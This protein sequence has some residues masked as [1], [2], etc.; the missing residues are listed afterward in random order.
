MNDVKSIGL[1]TIGDLSL[2]FIALLAFG[3]FGMFVKGD[4]NLVWL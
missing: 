3:I 2:Y 1:K 4:I